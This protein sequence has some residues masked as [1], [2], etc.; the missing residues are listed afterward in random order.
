[1]VTTDIQRR[2]SRPEVE[3]T[4]A[5]DFA[6][7]LS[8]CNERR[9]EQSTGNA[10]NEHSPIHHRIPLYTNKSPAILRLQGC[11]ARFGDHP[12]LADKH[13]STTAMERNALRPQLADSIN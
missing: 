4:D 9:G 7:L 6:L 11:F 10:A 5:P 13:R 1:V 8:A 2:L 3:K 12:V